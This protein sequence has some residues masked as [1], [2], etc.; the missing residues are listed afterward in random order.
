MAAYSIFLSYLRRFSDVTDVEFND[1]FRPVLIERKFEKK[2]LLNGVN[3][4]LIC[5]ASDNKGFS[6]MFYL[7]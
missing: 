3:R 1:Y 6:P 4:M 7:L 2:Q 5:A